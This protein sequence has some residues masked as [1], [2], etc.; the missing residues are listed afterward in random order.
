LEN[1]F[2][3][4]IHGP[5]RSDCVFK[6]NS[7]MTNRNEVHNC[8][9]AIKLSDINEMQHDDLTDIWSLLKKN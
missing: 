9:I 6:T 5:C 8:I 2:C 7:V 1:K 4:F 3:P